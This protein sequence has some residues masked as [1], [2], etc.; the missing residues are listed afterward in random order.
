[1]SERKDAN[2]NRL[3]CDLDDTDLIFSRW[4]R[5]HGYSSS[6]VARYVAS[7][8][9]ESPAHGVYIRKGWEGGAQTL[10]VREGMSVVVLP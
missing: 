10:Q 2:I 3:L 1:M 6:L 7:G 8:W 9:L 4:L 5:T